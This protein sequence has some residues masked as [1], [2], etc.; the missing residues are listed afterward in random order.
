MT[1][2]KGPPRAIGASIRAAMCQK[3]EPRHSDLAL[4]ISI[5]HCPQNNERTEE[6][7]RLNNQRPACSC[8][9][10]DLRSSRQRNTQSGT[11][12][13]NQESQRRK[14]LGGSES[15]IGLQ[16]SKRVCYRRTLVQRL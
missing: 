10:V 5:R 4:A 2:T 8:P 13:R 11:R 15:V 7:R 9:P 3:V 1:S 12:R 14:T 6:S 16:S